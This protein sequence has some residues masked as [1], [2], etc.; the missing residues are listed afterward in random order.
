M[1]TKYFKK[2]LL[3]IGIAVFMCG[4][5]MQASA[6]TFDYSQA[7]GF[8]V[9]PGE[10]LSTHVGDAQN[11]I[12]WFQNASN[13]QPPA[14]Y[15]NTIAWGASNNDGGGIA[16]DPFVVG[17]T[18]NSSTALSAMSVFGVAGQVSTG[19]GD[20]FGNWVTIST[21]SHQNNAILSS[22]Y[23]LASAVIY[24]E[25]SFLAPVNYTD[26]N[27]IPISFTETRNTAPC[28]GLGG[29]VCPDRFSFNTAGFAPVNFL[30]D[31]KNYE[32]AFQLANF[33]NST[34]DSSSDPTL[35]VWTDERVTS[36]LDVQ[37]HIRQVVPEPTTLVLLGLGLLGL[38]FTKRR[39]E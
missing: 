34:L 16:V 21:L 33:V 38:G 30:Y 18:G 27:T 15:F 13:P 6:I 9:V 23:S 28:A 24:S 32:V 37:M 36:S 5:S 12:K 17:N 2:A 1:R 31:G 8:S 35:T 7:A 25:L 11:D 20:A 39:K 26:V 14:G 29:T 19:D 4:F 10:L 3:V 22:W